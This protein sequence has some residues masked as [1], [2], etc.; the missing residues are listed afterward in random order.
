MFQIHFTLVNFSILR[1]AVG[2]PELATEINSETN[3][4]LRIIR[5][6]R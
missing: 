2:I 1:D 3:V 4:R 5:N 6:A